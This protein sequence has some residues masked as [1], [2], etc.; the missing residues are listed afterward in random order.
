MWPQREAKQSPASSAN[1]RNVWSYTSTHYVAVTVFI[2]SLSVCLSCSSISHTCCT[3]P[4][5]FVLLLWHINIPSKAT[6][7]QKPVSVRTSH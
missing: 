3:V 4:R 6:V 5:E 7:R 2:N 1:L